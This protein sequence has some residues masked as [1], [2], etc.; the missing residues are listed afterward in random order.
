M[1]LLSDAANGGLVDRIVLAPINKHLSLVFF[2]GVVLFE[3]RQAREQA[4]EV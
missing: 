3:G 1:P 2:S 4:F